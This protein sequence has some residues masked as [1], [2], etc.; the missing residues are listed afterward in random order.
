[1]GAGDLPAGVSQAVIEQMLEESGDE[2]TIGERVIR[3]QVLTRGA[4]IAGRAAIAVGAAAVAG[5]T[6]LK[7]KPVT[8][9]GK[10]EF[11]P[12]Y[13]T[14]KQARAEMKRVRGTHMDR[15]YGPYYDKAYWRRTKH[16]SRLSFFHEHT[17]EKRFNQALKHR[18]QAN[19]RRGT[20]LRGAGATMI[21][22]GKM[23]PVVAYGYIAWDMKRRWHKGEDVD[24]VGEVDA[25]AKD[26]LYA[27][28]P[29][30]FWTDVYTAY[31]SANIIYGGVIKPLAAAILRHETGGIL[32]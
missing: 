8:L 23:L 4:P 3:N 9:K 1:M 27:G 6:A 26:A 2:L 10:T 21:V 11:S 17:Q 22:A 7:R 25:L 16:A 30:E 15:K 32:G 12:N 18:Q 20:V 5:G 29:E 13:L 28:D 14:K 19:L 31:T 24:V